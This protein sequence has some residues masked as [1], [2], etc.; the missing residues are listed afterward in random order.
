MF[1]S[2]VSK[3]NLKCQLPGVLT[4]IFKKNDQIHD[5]NT[6]LSKHL[7]KPLSETNARKFAV[8]NKGV[9]IHNSLTDGIRDSW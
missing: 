3:S 7:H 5:H 9:D 2:Q 4:N 6:P 8:A 1:I